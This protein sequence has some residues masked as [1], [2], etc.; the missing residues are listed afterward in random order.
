MSYEYYVGELN[1]YL[2][3]LG[4]VCGP[5]HSFGVKAE[6]HGGRS[7]SDFV[8][9]ILAERNKYHSE[10]YVDQEVIN[11]D[12]L[13]DRIESMIFGGQMRNLK[14]N[15]NTGDDYATVFIEDINEYFGLISTSMNKEGVFH[16]LL[17]STVFGIEV[18]NEECESS[19]YF[20]LGIEDLYI[21]VYFC[22][23]R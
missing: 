5:R 12:Q 22:K 6:R 20:A 9:H 10:V 1:G 4:R 13:F 2:K 15:K 19:F 14:P 16:P 3:A 18:L 17:N 8:Q 7:I 23:R 11:R 21:F